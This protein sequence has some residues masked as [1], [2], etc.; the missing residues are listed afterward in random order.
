MTAGAWSLMA[1]RG[2]PRTPR[3][4]VS[5]CEKSQASME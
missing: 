5:N 4:W 1:G 3:I 2:W